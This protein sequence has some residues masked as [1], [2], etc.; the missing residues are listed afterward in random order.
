MIQDNDLYSKS[1]QAIKQAQTLMDYF[2]KTAI[3]KEIHF[4]T[5]PNFAVKP[6]KI[7][8]FVGMLNLDKEEVEV[9]G[10]SQ[11]YIVSKNNKPER[12]LELDKY[13]DH[14]GMFYFTNINLGNNDFETYNLKINPFYT[15]LNIPKSVK[16]FCS[17]KSP[18]FALVSS[19][20]LLNRPI[21]IVKHDSNSPSKYY[22]YSF[23]NE[24]VGPSFL[25]F[26]PGKFGTAFKHYSLEDIGNAQYKLTLTALISPRSQK[27]LNIAGIDP[28]Y[29]MIKIIDIF[30]FR[31]FGIYKKWR[32]KLE[33]Q[34]MKHHV[35]V[36]EEMLKNLIDSDVEKTARNKL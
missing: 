4:Y 12:V 25:G 11:E 34:M 10:T 33:L 1:K 23:V 7:R 26:G 8:C 27:I 14:K 22:C 15:P 32:A 16:K 36:H 20:K 5:H 24:K 9:L 35:S 6:A 13:P 19:S 2:Y 21:G 28:I 30:T 18:M 3:E 29:G 17:K 31:Q